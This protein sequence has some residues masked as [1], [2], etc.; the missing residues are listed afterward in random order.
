MSIASGG[1]DR[2]GSK[3]WLLRLDNLVLTLRFEELC[4]KVPVNERFTTCRGLAVDVEDG[5]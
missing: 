3:P 2:R 5:V 4:D 1:C